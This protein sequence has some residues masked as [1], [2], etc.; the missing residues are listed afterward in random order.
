MLAAHRRRPGACPAS[1]GA[2]R[3]PFGEEFGTLGAA[4]ADWRCTSKP[5]KLYRHFFRWHGSKFQ[6]SGVTPPTAKAYLLADNGR[7][8]LKLSHKDM[9][10]QCG[11]DPRIAET[12]P[13]RDRLKAIGALQWGRDPRIAET[14]APLSYSVFKD[15]R[16]PFRAPR[17]L[18]P[19]HSPALPPHPANPLNPSEVTPRER[20]PRFPRHPAARAASP[21]NKN[22]ILTDLPL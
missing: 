16:N 13:V 7:K 21:R 8:P 6:L 14:S 2:G 9:V 20:P 12:Y 17:Q 4:K 22:R 5:G 19:S 18:R 11:R 10:L 3:T 15:L 1:G